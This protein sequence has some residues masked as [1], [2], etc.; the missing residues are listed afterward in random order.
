[1]SEQDVMQNKHRHL[2]TNTGV[3]ASSHRDAKPNWLW[4]KVS[5]RSA[6]WKNVL[7]D[8]GSA[9]N[10]ASVPEPPLGFERGIDRTTAGAE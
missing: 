2:S 3:S 9:G 8:G 5:G 7:S 10:N 4:Q 1:M 6:L